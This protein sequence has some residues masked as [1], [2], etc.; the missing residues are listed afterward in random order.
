[1]KLHYLLQEM[2]VPSIP[3]LSNLSILQLIIITGRADVRKHIKV[4]SGIWHALHILTHPVVK[5]P[6]PK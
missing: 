4:A 2:I 5:I 6:S 3:C 1:M